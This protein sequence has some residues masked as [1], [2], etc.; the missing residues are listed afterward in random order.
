M[1]RKRDY[2]GVLLDYY[3]FIQCLCIVFNLVIHLSLNFSPGNLNEDRRTIWLEVRFKLDM[4]THSF[5]KIPK[6]AL[7][8]RGFQPLLS[9]MT[10]L[11]AMYSLFILPNTRLY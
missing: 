5:I 2:N 1:Q 6:V 9:Q 3:P 10:D 4:E 11:R 7:V 8:G